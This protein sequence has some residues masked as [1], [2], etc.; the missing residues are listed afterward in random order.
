MNNKL[1]QLQKYS[2]ITVCEFRLSLLRVKKN[3]I[4]WTWLTIGKWNCKTKSW[5]R[6]RELLKIRNKHRIYKIKIVINQTTLFQ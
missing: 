3:G 2:V 6:E 5:T 4:F 1:E